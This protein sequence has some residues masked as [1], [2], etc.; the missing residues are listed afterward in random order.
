MS[1]TGYTVEDGH[2]DLQNLDDGTKIRYKYRRGDFAGTV[3]EAEVREG[4]IVYDGER[5]S[6]TG[7]ARVA[8]RNVRGEEYE[9][10]GWE[11]WEYRDD[12]DKW[13]ELKNIRE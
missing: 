3:I 13:T 10:N 4:H 6:P 9:V 5:Y 8:L 2:P 1:K 12:E 11:W 7:A